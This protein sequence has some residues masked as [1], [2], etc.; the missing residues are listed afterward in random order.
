M[1]L[2]EEGIGNVCH[3]PFYDEKT[4]VEFFDSLKLSRIL[5]G[6]FHLG[7]YDKVTEL[8]D[9]DRNE[10]RSSSALNPFALNTLRMKAFKQECGMIQGKN[11]SLS[12]SS[13]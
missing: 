10:L 1:V 6:N 12:C 8:L 3:Y 9:P 2:V 4:A 13:I 11:E 7:N 5:L